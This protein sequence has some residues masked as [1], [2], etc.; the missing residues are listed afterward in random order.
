MY[1]QLQTI[2]HSTDITMSVYAL[3]FVVLSY[4]SAAV[5]CVC[6]E[7]PLG[8]MEIL[9]FKLIGIGGRDSQRE[10]P[11]PVLAKRKEKLS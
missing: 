10:G 11:G 2:V 7:F 9:L 3:A 6:I 5:F 4:A 8:T 1:G